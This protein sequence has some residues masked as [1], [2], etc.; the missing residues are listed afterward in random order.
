MT[1]EWRL[2]ILKCPKLEVDYRV[3]YTIQNRNSLERRAYNKMLNV[4]KYKQLV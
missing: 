2:K 4:D 1:T 3:Y